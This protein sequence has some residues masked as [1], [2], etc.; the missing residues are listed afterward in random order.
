MGPTL[1]KI[2]ELM[3]SPA[4][5]ELTSNQREVVA[6]RELLGLIAIGGKLN[7]EL[8][9]LIAPFNDLV[10]EKN[11]NLSDFIEGINKALSPKLEEAFKLNNESWNVF[12]NIVFSE[13][14]SGR[15]AIITPEQIRALP[16]EGKT[17]SRENEA[18]RILRMKRINGEEPSS[19]ID[20]EERQEVSA[21]LI[22]LKEAV[23]SYNMAI[24]NDLMGAFDAFC[25]ALA[26]KSAE[27]NSAY[28]KNVQ[29]IEGK[30]R[31][32]IEAFQY[33]TGSTLRDE[34]E[35]YRKNIEM[36]SEKYAKTIMDLNE[37]FQSKEIKS[38]AFAQE[39]KEAQ[40][41]HEHEL[42]KIGEEPKALEVF[43]NRLPEGVKE[44]ID[45]NELKSKIEAKEEEL[46]SEQLTREYVNFS[47]QLQSVVLKGE[48]D[49][50]MARIINE[51]A[52]AE[53]NQQIPS[54][55]SRN[56]KIDEIM[57]NQFHEK[58][59]TEINKK[60]DDQKNGL[61]KFEI[62]LRENF[63][64]K[65]HEELSGNFLA[66]NL[67]GIKD[68]L[69]NEVIQFA[70]K[71]AIDIKL[72]PNMLEINKLFTIALAL[73]NN[74]GVKAKDAKTK[75]FK[76]IAQSIVDMLR[77]SNSYDRI[78]SFI[79]LYGEV[80][81]LAKQQA[82][83][84]DP[85]PEQAV[86][87][88][89][90]H[91]TDGVSAEL[92]AE[93]RI[94]KIVEYAAELEKMKTKSKDP[95]LDKL[96]K[97][98]KNKLILGY[99]RN[100]EALSDKL[101]RFC[102]ST[103]SHEKTN[104]FT[105]I[106]D[107]IIPNLIELE[108]NLLLM[109]DDSL[110][111]G[112]KINLR[113][114]GLKDLSIATLIDHESKAEYLPAIIRTF[115]TKEIEKLKNA[116]VEGEGDAIEH[117]STFVRLLRLSNHKSTPQ[118][119]AQSVAPLLRL[120]KNISNG[121][122][123]SIYNFMIE[124]FSES[125]DDIALA[126]KLLFDAFIDSPHSITIDDFITR[127]GE[128]VHFQP[129]HLEMERRRKIMEN[130]IIKTEEGIDSMLSKFENVNK[131]QVFT[132]DIMPF[133]GKKE[134]E[135]ETISLIKKA[136]EILKSYPFIAISISKERWPHEASSST[137]MAKVKNIVQKTITP[138]G[139][140]VEELNKI[141]EF[142][143]TLQSSLHGFFDEMASSVSTFEVVLKSLTKSLAPND[144]RHDLI[145][146]YLVREYFIK[147]SGLAAHE[148]LKF[149]GNINLID[150]IML[151][152]AS[153]PVIAAR[154]YLKLGDYYA[155]DNPTLAIMYYN[156]IIDSER[157]EFR[158]IRPKALTALLNQRFAGR[159]DL[160]RMNVL[161]LSINELVSSPREPDTILTQALRGCFA[162]I[163]PD[164]MIEL[165]NYTLLVDVTK[166]RTIFEPEVID[167]F[168]HSL[169]SQAVENKSAEKL[170]SEINLF[171]EIDPDKH[172]KDIDSRIRKVLD[173]NL[174]ARIKMN[175]IGSILVHLAAIKGKALSGPQQNTCLELPMLSVIDQMRDQSSAVDLVYKNSLEIIKHSRALQQVSSDKFC[176]KFIEK[177]LNTLPINHNGRS[178]LIT[179]AQTLARTYADDVDIQVV[180]GSITKNIGQSSTTAPLI[181]MRQPNPQQS[182]A[183]S[184]PALEA[185]VTICRELKDEERV[186]HVIEL[187]KNISK[188]GSEIAENEFN[189][190]K[191]RFKDNGSY[192][193]AVKKIQLKDL[194]Q[195]ANAKE[196]KIATYVEELQDWNKKNEIKI[197]F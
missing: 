195:Y 174:D 197:D 136:A 158:Q 40:D 148:I 75:A 169:R 106:L 182:K 189:G 67:K 59:K 186:N 172:W 178:A 88:A 63:S 10:A 68:V 104:L 191:S 111:K 115:C 97:G 119:F 79:K 194:Q 61:L 16:G 100:A 166:L 183:P 29:E 51:K 66:M 139:Q 120:N 147:G 157:P 150:H 96:E 114:F 25:K 121:L 152:E 170:V 45:N 60:Y 41:L 116:T 77:I 44:A 181:M 165:M 19:N 177:I 155:A 8:D 110:V 69:G 58:L 109:M 89:Y 22:D 31:R 113:A 126:E 188:P 162:Q 112:T 43:L 196:N 27:E 192:E 52:M 86:D 176:I 128:W 117:F 82:I 83:V 146:N 24:K 34:K 102:R 144:S 135:R 42:K 193:D 5:K 141:N 33:Y 137:R 93:L 78:E 95:S 173:S 3:G 164:K 30:R 171:L 138:Y 56:K 124:S 80:F 36:A 23:N 130:S 73:E 39:M 161:Q 84:I 55:S 13:M 156:K 50:K 20:L 4:Y 105:E 65:I 35:T 149:F 54:D 21:I 187:L 118:Q 53:I 76:M 57:R 62:I 190:W 81:E 108:K 153:N 143:K 47:R 133:E 160:D 94:A 71:I 163:S 26:I 129:F 92:H 140:A 70:R 48:F 7:P 168:V 145:A 1:Q 64:K 28:K 74:L 142:N 14:G 101:D 154:H 85:L 167:T 87:S 37:K 107:K 6:I 180:I 2:L 49:E 17:L 185:L 159:H 175:V 46:K 99:I 38:D 127:H 9:P 18:L 11:N 12:F 151:I 122:L 32:E 123:T 72:H 90:R 125:S 98:I 91:W 184:Y 179:I 132:L 103:G 134:L 131:P 15:E